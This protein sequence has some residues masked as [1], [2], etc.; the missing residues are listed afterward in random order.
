MKNNVTLS[1]LLPSRKRFSYLKETITSLLDLASNPDKIEILVKLDYDDEESLS[2]IS[3]LPRIDNLK[4]IVSTRRNGYQSINLFQNELYALSTGNWLMSMNDDALMN[5]KDYDLYYEQCPLEMPHT[6]FHLHTERSGGME[7]FCCCNR[8]WCEVQGGFFSPCLYS[9][10]FMLYIARKLGNYSQLP[11]EIIHRVG[12]DELSIGRDET[13]LEKEAFQI[14][15]KGGSMQNH[16]SAAWDN[17]LPAI[18]ECYLKLKNFFE[19]NQ[20]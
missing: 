8:K 20:K 12:N 10:G 19:A 2:R 15:D 6:I 9:D 3:E 7:L 14:Q 17:C 5:T 18:D 16:G 13:L 11:I 4:T 1:F